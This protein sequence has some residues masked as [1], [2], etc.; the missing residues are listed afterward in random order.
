M[1]PAADKMEIKIKKQILKVLQS[2]S[3][4]V[5]AKPVN[6]AEKIKNLLI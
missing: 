3:C 1:K 6:N 2:I 4:N 5:T